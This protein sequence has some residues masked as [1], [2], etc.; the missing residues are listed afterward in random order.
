MNNRP[1]IDTRA[2]LRNIR[3]T[4]NIESVKMS[5]NQL[6]TEILQKI[7]EYTT[8]QDLLHLAQTSKRNYRVFLGRRMHLLEQS[9]QNS[10]SPLPDLYKLVISN[11]PDKSRKPLGTEIRRN[12]IVNRIIETR[13]TPKLTLELLIKMAIY[14]KIADRWT[15]LYPQIRW[16][17]NFSNR[18]L[19]RLYEQERL[20]GAIYRHWTYNSLF[21]DQIF[22]HFDPDLPGSRD[23][24]R[25]R[26]LRTYTTIE[27]VQLTEYVDKMRQLL[28]TDLYPSYSV[29]RHS[30]S[31]PVPPR[32]LVNL[33]WGNGTFHRRLVCDLMKYSPA[34]LLYLFDETSTKKQRMEYLMARGISFADMPAT[35]RDSIALVMLE[36][37][38]LLDTERDISD[39]DIEYGIIDTPDT[40]GPGYYSC[41]QYANDASLDGIFVNGLQV[42][43]PLSTNGDLEQQEED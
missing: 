43:L 32:T 17:H 33:G 8:L 7:Y 11:E 13:K 18:R 37:K 2:R 30:Y 31:E 35:L 1:Y 15:E 23:D 19:L 27:L 20:R 12:L 4:C 41:H 21:H 36:R 39:E 40:V 42:R 9:M 28:E 26:I 22:M 10:Y 14:G 29:I 3:I 38:V 5:I 25:L 6:S 34:D 24:P 16:R